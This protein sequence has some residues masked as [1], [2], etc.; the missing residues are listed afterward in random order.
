MNPLTELFKEEAM[1]ESMI[2]LSDEL[3]NVSC[4][5]E[6]EFN[7]FKIASIKYNIFSLSSQTEY[8][9]KFQ[10]LLNSYYSVKKFKYPSSETELNILIYQT[11][12][13]AFLTYTFIENLKNFFDVIGDHSEYFNLISEIDSIDLEE[14]K[15]I[16]YHFNLLIVLDKKL[17]ELNNLNGLIYSNKYSDIELNPIRTVM[18]DNIRNIEILYDVKRLLLCD[19][20]SFTYEQSIMLFILINRLTNRIIEKSEKFFDRY[21]SEG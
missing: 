16:A 8:S 12:T 14:E 9:K 19:N 4:E 3:I 20:L 7:P 15:K 10:E 1:R 11:I 17:E 13:K 5:E 2:V 6:N 18:K 21:I